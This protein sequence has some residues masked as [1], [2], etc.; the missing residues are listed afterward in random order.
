MLPSTTCPLPCPSGLQ[1]PHQTALFKK[2][3]K[4]APHTM[5]QYKS[6]KNMNCFRKPPKKG[7]PLFIRSHYKTN[8]IRYSTTVDW[9]ADGTLGWQSPTV[10][11]WLLWKSTRLVK[12]GFVPSWFDTQIT[13][14]C[15]LRNIRFLV[16]VTCCQLCIN[17]PGM[18]HI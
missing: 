15:L 12:L 8:Q 4:T 17:I 16:I 10:L 3:Y 18:V 2:F 13:P 6:M 9:L 14:F 1:L 5:N 11:N 7:I